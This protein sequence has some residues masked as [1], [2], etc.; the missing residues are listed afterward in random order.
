MKTNIK[1]GGLEDTLKNPAQLKINKQGK[2]VTVKGKTPI[3][4]KIVR[5]EEIFVCSRK[6]MQK[7]YH[8]YTI[9]RAMLYAFSS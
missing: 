7:F 2:I 1:V 3:F 9:T 8:E 5:D 6:D 4:P